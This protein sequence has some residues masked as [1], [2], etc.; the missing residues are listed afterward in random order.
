MWSTRRWT[1]TAVTGP[2]T[3]LQQPAVRQVQ[4][5]ACQP[6]AGSPAFGV[7]VVRVFRK[8]GSGKVVRSET[9]H[10]QYQ[11]A[12]TVRCGRPKKPRQS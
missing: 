3:G 4:A 6:A 7:D 12:D 5:G 10:T 11:A 9:F 8:P 2:R 1:V